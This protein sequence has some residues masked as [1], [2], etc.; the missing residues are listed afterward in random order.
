MWPVAVIMARIG[1]AQGPP[2]Q[3]AF[4]SKFS[5]FHRIIDKRLTCRKPVL[6]IRTLNVHLLWGHFDFTL[7]RDL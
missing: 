7:F 3:S 4:S 5:G 6:D 2:P 1:E